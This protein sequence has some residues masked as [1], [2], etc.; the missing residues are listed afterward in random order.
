MENGT[1]K[2]K[3]KTVK[4]STLLPTLEQH[5]LPITEVIFVIVLLGINAFGLYYILY[6][7]STLQ[8]AANLSTHQTTKGYTSLNQILFNQISSQ[9]ENRILYNTYTSITPTVVKNPF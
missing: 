9:R 6:N 7:S 1:E 4:Q 3:V 8:S 5:L 2:Q